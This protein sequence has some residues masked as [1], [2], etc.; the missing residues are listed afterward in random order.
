[1]FG[2]VEPGLLIALE[3]GSISFATQTETVF[4]A[5]RNEIGVNWPWWEFGAGVHLRVAGKI[6]RLSLTRP[7]N[8]ADIDFTG[9]GS[10]GAALASGKAWKKYLATQP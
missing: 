4:G 3:G 9:I 5:D 2:R 7:P 6:Y 8:G 10:I 1:M